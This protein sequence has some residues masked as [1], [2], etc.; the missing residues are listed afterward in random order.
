LKYKA[1]LFD[2]DGTLLDTLED[3][4][5]AVNNGLSLLGFPRHKVESYKYFVGAGREE[6]AWRALP[7]NERHPA[8]LKRLVDFIDQDYLQHWADHSRPYPGIPELLDALTAR[9]VK[10]TVLSNKPQTFTDLMVTR[11]LSQWRFEPVVGAL[12]G[13]PKKPDP[14]TALGIAARLNLRPQELIY[15]GDS[16][17]DMQTATASGMYPVGALWGFRTADELK[18][19]GAS[20]LINQP[21]ELLSFLR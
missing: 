20:E 3:L 8:T 10:L 5:G 19:S 14:G 6:M 1:V 18:Q 21:D 7:E 15:L 13:V 17:I 2:L 12:P 4:A 16:D 9:R 11:L